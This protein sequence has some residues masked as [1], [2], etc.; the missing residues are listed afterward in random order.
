M[1][2]VAFGALVHFHRRG[3]TGPG[4]VA[5]QEPKRWPHAW[6]LV[7]EHRCFCGCFPWKMVIYSGK[8]SF[9][10]DLPIENGDFP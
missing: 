1:P 8:L 2:S 4:P 7:V 6:A 9:I 10:V 3:A 5:V